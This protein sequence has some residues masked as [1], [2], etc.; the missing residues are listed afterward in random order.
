MLAPAEVIPR[1]P[2]SCSVV[3]R[4]SRVK[5]TAKDA[6]GNPM[7]CCRFRFQGRPLSGSIF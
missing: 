7:W 6:L 4:C 2:A 3:H 5:E 1:L